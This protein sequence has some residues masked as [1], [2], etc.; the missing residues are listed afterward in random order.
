MSEEENNNTKL[1]TADRIYNHFKNGKGTYYDEAY[2]C[3]L[4]IETM[5]N[6]LKGTISS[7]CVQAMVC[8]KTFGNWVNAHPLFAAIY[9][10]SKM[11][12][13][14]EWEK[15]GQRIRDFDF[16]M[17]T[18]N[19][20]FEHWKMMGW[21][22]FGI[23]KVSKIKLSVPKDASPMQLYQQILL[24]ATE[25]DFTAPEFKQLMEAVNIGLNVNQTIELQR[26]IDE[27]KS[28]LITMEQNSNV[29]NPFTNKGTA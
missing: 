2:H 8:E 24:Q 23:S 26:Q 7:F 13:R 3:K 10:F 16:P 25:G 6:P 28:A 5:L 18:M 12:A 22:R 17:G 15:E 27:L 29:Q 11:L 1:S 20:S 19:Y 4:L 14:E 9:S 21:S